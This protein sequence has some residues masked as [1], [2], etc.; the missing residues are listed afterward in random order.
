MSE[1][2]A[3]TGPLALVIV[4]SAFGNTRKIAAAVAEGLGE[5]T[6]LISVDLAP[7]VLPGSVRLLVVG[8]PTHAF[9]MST[10]SS[11]G[12]A[13][14]QGAAVT[15]GIRE[16]ITELR[17]EPTCNVATFDTRQ[18]SMRRLPGSAARRA[19]KALQRKGFP[20][21]GQPQNFYVS[22]TAGPLVDGELDRARAWGEQLSQIVRG[23][24]PD[25]QQHIA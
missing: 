7:A 19:A 11:R 18:T 9:G 13:A 4:E 15:R 24:A 22:G 10:P 21:V 12:S 16:W 17:V 6:E 23:S 5:R 1:Q 8:G 20:A 3:A 25:R 14:R 2:K